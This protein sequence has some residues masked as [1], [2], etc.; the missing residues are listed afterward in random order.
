MAVRPGVLVE[1]D[2]PRP[3][4]HEVPRRI[5]ADAHTRMLP[6]AICSAP[7]EVAV[8]ACGPPGPCSGG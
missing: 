3:D 2:L 1:G 5:R 4:G 8:L 7:A 6:V